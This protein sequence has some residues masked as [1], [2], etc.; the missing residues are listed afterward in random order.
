MTPIRESAIEAKVVR[1]CRANGYYCRKLSAIASNGMPDRMI[2][3]G[4]KVLFLELKRPGNKP[5]PLQ[6]REMRLLTEA[7]MYATWCDS[8]EKAVEIMDD[9]FA[10]NEDEVI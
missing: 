6:E 3:H 8:Y 7:G 9:W 10:G 5:T 2:C 1:H 4:G